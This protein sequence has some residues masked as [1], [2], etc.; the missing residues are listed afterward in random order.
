MAALGLC[1]SV[2][3]FSSYGEQ[4]LLLSVAVYELLI[5]VRAQALGTWTQQLSHPCLLALCHV[6]SSWTRD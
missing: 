4:G 3:A 2:Q 1:C 6:E 5:A